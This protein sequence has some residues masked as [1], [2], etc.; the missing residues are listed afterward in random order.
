MVGLRAGRVDLAAHL[1]DYESELLP[2]IRLTV[3]SVQ[4]IFAM[5]AQTDLLL[6]DVQFLKIEYHLLLKPGRINLLLKVSKTPLEP[7]PD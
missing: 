3:N 7:L 2:G 6:I 1:L 4:E 5:L